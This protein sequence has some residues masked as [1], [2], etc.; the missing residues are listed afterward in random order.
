MQI[1]TLGDI[2][3]HY[4]DDGDPA[5]APVVFAN[6]LGTDLRLWDAVLPLLP[7]GLRLIR[8]DMRGHGLTDAP[9]APYSMGGLIT[10]AERLI[11]HLG[12]RDCVFVGLS[13]GGMIAQGLAAKRLDLIRAL[14]LSNTA[15]RIGTPAIWGER[16][17]AVAAGGVEPLADAVMER[18][19]S[20]PFRATPGMRLWRN[21]LTG[22]PAQGY[23]GCSAAISGTDLMTPTSGL[24][25]P[26]LAIAG[27]EDGSTPPDLV[28]ET[29]DLIPGS[30]FHLIRGAGHLPCVERPD[31]FAAVLTDFLTRIGHAAR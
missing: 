30:Q 26:T 31:A 4:R 18:W 19:F 11:D 3:V 29:A 13:I 15:A 23:A 17:A 1:A 7:P 10:D 8:Y 12:V 2:H 28:R 20:K 27:S 21:M 6:S 9:P 5:G 25:L 22:T 16:I 24:R 14:V